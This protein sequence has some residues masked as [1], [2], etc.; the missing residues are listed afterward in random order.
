MDII[1]AENEAPYMK[2]LHGRWV[3]YGEDD[4]RSPTD[5]EELMAA[6]LESQSLP[7]SRS[8]MRDACI[9]CGDKYQTRVKELT[10]STLVLT[11]K[12]DELTLKSGRMVKL[13]KSRGVDFEAERDKEVN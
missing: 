12:V 10:K 1:G 11:D 7:M 9:S 3:V 6:Q 5:M 4:A 2:K 13:L 8:E